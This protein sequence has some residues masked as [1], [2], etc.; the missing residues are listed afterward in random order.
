VARGETKIVW[1]DREIARTLGALVRVALVVMG[2][3]FAAPLITGSETGAF[4]KLG[5]HLLVAFALAAAPILASASVGAVTVL[6]HHLRLG[7][8]VTIGKHRGRVQRFGLTDMLLKAGDD[9]VRVP[10]LLALV[11]PVR[12]H[13]QD[14]LVVRLC[15]DTGAQHALA[16]E[17]LEGVVREICEDGRVALVEI[18]TSGAHYTMTLPVPDT[19][20]ARQRVLLHASAALVKSGLPL[21]QANRERAP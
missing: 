7:D 8:E 13:A 11:V 6:R 17:V 20:D 21:A 3:V 10:Y 2:L 5:T 19:G 14:S 15:V 9:A 18:D 1:V 4:A 12:I 16:L